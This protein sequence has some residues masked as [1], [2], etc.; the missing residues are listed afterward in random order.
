MIDGVIRYTTLYDLSTEPLLNWRS[1]VLPFGLAAAA[2]IAAYT[3][4]PGSGRNGLIAFAVI[5]VVVSV[6]IPLF[7]QYQLKH[8]KALKV[9]GPIVGYWEKEWTERRDGKNNHYSYEA[10]RVDTVSFGYYRNVEMAGFF[11]G[12][13]EQVSLRDGMAVRI[14]YVPERQLDDDRI[15]N[16][17]VKLEIGQSK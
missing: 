5:A 15:L 11:N 4:R 2:L 1:L 10:F 3:S 9:E 17:I 8:Q 14:H 12:G 6:G 7:D 13:P 16:R